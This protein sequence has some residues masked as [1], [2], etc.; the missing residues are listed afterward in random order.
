M[1]ITSLRH[2]ITVLG[3][4]SCNAGC[5]LFSTPGEGDVANGTNA[6]LQLAATRGRLMELL[7]ERV[8]PGNREF[9]DQAFM[10]GILSLMPALLL[11]HHADHPGAATGRTPHRPCTTSKDGQL[12]YLI[13]L[14]EATESADT[15]ALTEALRHLPN[16]NVAFINTDLRKPCW[17]SGLWQTQAND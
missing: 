17:A 12:G 13:T 5:N 14:V 4:V 15:E 3:G 8:Q 2:A 9:A 16:V 11:C 1:R 6:L 7:A 10:T